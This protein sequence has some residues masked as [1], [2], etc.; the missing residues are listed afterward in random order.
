MQPSRT[1]DLVTARGPSYDRSFRVLQ[2][3]PCSAARDAGL[4]HSCRAAAGNFREH[5]ARRDCPSPSR[6]PNPK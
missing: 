5:G 2:V 1:S 3:P 4:P 6:R